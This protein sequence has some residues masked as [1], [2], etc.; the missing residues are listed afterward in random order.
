MFDIAIEFLNILTKS[1]YKA[2]L[3]GGYVRDRILGIESLDID[4]NTNATPKEV[5][6]LFGD[7]CSV[8]DDYGSVIVN[9]KNIRF[10]VTT[11]RKELDYSDGRHPD[12]VEYI[13]DLYQDLVRRDFTIN[14]LC[15][16]DE[17]NVID[18]LAG[19][20]D[21]VKR[22]IKTVG[23]AN[24]RFS[25]DALRILRAV[26][27]A[28]VLGFDMDEDVKI[29]IKNNRHL[30]KNISYNRK[31]D[32][33]EK[34]FSSKEIDSVIGLLIE[35]GLDKELELNNLEKINSSI[36]LMGIW[37]LVDVVNIYPFS[38]NEKDIISS[39][40]E[41]LSL[42][43]LD[44]YTLYKYGLYVCSVA[45]EIVNVDKRL[46]SEVYSNLSIK[47][48]KDIDISSEEIM[49]LLNIGPCEYLGKVIDG[50][51]LAILYNKVLNKKEELSSYIVNN[52]NR[53]AC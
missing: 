22:V 7:S 8:N 5:R 2:Y 10:E 50:I 26:R 18:F 20:D 15:I 47:D 29:A 23:D 11:F 13:D 41:V 1:S 33:L 46:I 51:E 21:L 43:L 31:K 38:N 17:G 49:S 24:I 37:A 40:N 3:V 16:D 25:E 4:V 34:I 35:L 39:I 48:K 42:D 28:A 12:K 32:E 53:D 14:T 9:Y 30:L 6:A 45:C 36:T 44:P 19:N 27:F 52:Y